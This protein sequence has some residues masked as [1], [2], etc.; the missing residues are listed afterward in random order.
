MAS[1]AEAHLRL[2]HLEEAELALSNAS[3]L[4]SSSPHSSVKFFGIV[5]NS[6]MY[7]VRA[8]VELARGRYAEVKSKPS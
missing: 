4:D 2:H 5:S 8:Q 3:K 1:K 7:V 6:Y